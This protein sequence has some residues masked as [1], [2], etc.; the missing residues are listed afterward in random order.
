MLAA[1]GLLVLALIFSRTVPGIGGLLAVAGVLL[2]IVGYSM[3]F[4]K[5]K[6]LEKRW[7]GQVVE[8]D[9]PW[10]SRFRRKPR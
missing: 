6:K 5:P 1:A 4:M 2:F 3:V 10:W 8:D 9:E 7:R